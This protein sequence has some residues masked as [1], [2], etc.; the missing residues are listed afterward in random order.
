MSFQE[1][2]KFVTFLGKCKLNRKLE[3]NTWI[4]KKLV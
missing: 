1:K 2:A 4:N 3:F